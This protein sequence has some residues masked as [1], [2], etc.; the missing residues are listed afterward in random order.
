MASSVLFGPEI[1]FVAPIKSRN[2]CSDNQFHFT[3]TSSRIIAVWAAGPPNAVNPSFRKSRAISLMLL[4]SLINEIFTLKL[5]VITVHNHLI[6][7]YFSKIYKVD[8]L[9]YCKVFW[10][11]N[12][13]IFL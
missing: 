6:N 8:R 2:C 4:C 1:K 7:I 12:I 3:T 9:D 11:I 13:K 5:L 10:L